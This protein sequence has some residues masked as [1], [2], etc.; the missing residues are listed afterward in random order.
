MSLAE[1]RPGPEIYDFTVSN[2]RDRLLAYF[3]LKN[4][5]PPYVQI[6]LESGVIVRYI[7]EVELQAPRFLLKKRLSRVS[8]SRT[9]SYDNLKGE[10]RVSFGPD[11][12]R[13][14][15]VR[16]LE[17]AKS[18]AFEINDVSVISL[19]ELPKGKTYIMRVR[20]KTEK[21]VSSLPFR[22]LLDLF[23]SWGYRTKWYEIRFNY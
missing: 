12:P 6:A 19:S 11:S 17:E 15:S 3:S 20:A 23:S 5:C 21:A 9:L 7:Y 8:I 22:G 18:L 16:T 13:V 4:G 14:V 10:Y 1:D 2:S